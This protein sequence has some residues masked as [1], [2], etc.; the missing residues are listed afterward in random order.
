MSEEL[1]N[2]LEDLKSIHQ[3]DINDLKRQYEAQLD[4]LKSS[5]ERANNVREDELRSQVASLTKT[6]QNTESSLNAIQKENEVQKA[7]IVSLIAEK[8]ELQATVK[9]LT[10]KYDTI[11]SMFAVEQRR[12]SSLESDC[13]A[14]RD[15]F[16]DMQEEIQRKAKQIEKLERHAKQQTSEVNKANNVIKQLSKELK[17]A[18]NK[19]KLRGQVATEQEKVLT[20]KEAEAEEAMTALRE[21]R[22]QLHAEEARRAQSDEQVLSLQAALEEAKKTIENNENIISWLNRQISESYTQSWQERLKA[23]GI[24]VVPSYMADKQPPPPIILPFGKNN[25]KLGISE[26]GSRP[27][28]S[29]TPCLTLPS[30]CS[31]NSGLGAMTCGTNSAVLP[32]IG[33][34]SHLPETGRTNTNAAARPSLKATGLLEGVASEMAGLTL[35]SPAPLISLTRQQP[36]SSAPNPTSKSFQNGGNSLASDAESSLS[37]PPKSGN[38]HQHSS[39]LSAYFPQKVTPS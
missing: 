31:G 14:Q 30:M 39:L 23:K 36:E 17:S 29:S 1:K 6:L 2:K 8:E 12:A 34:E 20:A 15:Q 38:Q 35:R 19:A 25:G 27:S 7:E 33:K 4:N 13:A 21:V 18:Q 26:A 37:R 28:T 10:T 16:R 9:Q 11:E 32:A 3:R 22:D 5:N 24:P